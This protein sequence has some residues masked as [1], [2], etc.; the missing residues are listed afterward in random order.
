M[1]AVCQITSDDLFVA[2]GLG[3]LLHL[4]TLRLS[5]R[6]YEETG[7]DHQPGALICVRLYVQMVINCHPEREACWAVLAVTL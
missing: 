2:P 5:G 1:H 4:L 7:Q 3:Y 6:W